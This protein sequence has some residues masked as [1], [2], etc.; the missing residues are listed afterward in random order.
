MSNPNLPG[1]ENTARWRAWFPVTQ[2][3]VYLNHAAVSPVSRQVRDAMVGLA[4]DVMNNGVAGIRRWVTI[5]RETRKL[6]ARLLGTDPRH[7]AFAKNTSEGLSWVA[8]GYPWKPGDEVVTARMEFPSNRFP[9]QNLANFGVKTVLVDDD[10][11]RLPADSLIA[12]MTDRTRVLA[13]SAVQFA[14]GYRSDLATLGSACRDRDILFVVDGIQQIGAMPL[15]PESVG[16]DVVV[17]DAHKWMLGPEGIAVAYL[18]DRALDVLRVAE[19]GWS[20]TGSIDFDAPEMVLHPDARRF[21]PG[22]PT[23]IALFGLHAALGLLE[24]VGNEVIA[25]RVLALAE[26]TRDEVMQRGWAVYGQPEPSERSG[27]VAFTIKGDPKR[28]GA[29]ALERGIMLTARSG[30]LRLSPHFYN[31]TDEIDR[32]LDVIRA[33]I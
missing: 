17:A 15:H 26:Y 5:Y 16:A 13:V 20:S 10:E 8:T 11:G 12:A 32:A 1:E 18:S 33:L 9:W 2:R 7:I 6:S 14:S 21:E 29:E 3:Y 23:T 22:T 30:R 24:D 19:V 27:I 4:D 25:E 28:V 31:T